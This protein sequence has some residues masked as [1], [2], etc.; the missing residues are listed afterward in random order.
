MSERGAKKF[1]IK[2]QVLH[3]LS[4]KKINQFLVIVIERQIRVVVYS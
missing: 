4:A 2:R 3:S 1:A